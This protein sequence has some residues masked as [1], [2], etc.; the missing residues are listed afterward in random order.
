ML[1]LMSFVAYGILY[2]VFPVL[3]IYVTFK[4]GGIT[5]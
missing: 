4:D 5:K 2:A 3:M 1:E